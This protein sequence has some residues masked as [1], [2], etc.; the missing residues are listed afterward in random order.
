M[1]VYLGTE[2][3]RKVNSFDR[4]SIAERPGGFSSIKVLNEAKAQLAQSLRSVKWLGLNHKP[5]AAGALAVNVSFAALEARRGDFKG[6]SSHV[7]SC[8][9]P[10]WIKIVFFLILKIMNPSSGL[11]LKGRPSD[12]QYY[13]TPQENLG[14]H[15][16]NS[17]REAKEYAIN[18]SGDGDFTSGHDSG[19]FFKTWPE[20]TGKGLQHS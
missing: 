9:N 8:P 3:S 11:I 10:S 5:L 17:F 1:S 13:D 12:Y 16:C 2:R 18:L 14:N 15:Q 4:K 20:E 6:W 19:F 7:S